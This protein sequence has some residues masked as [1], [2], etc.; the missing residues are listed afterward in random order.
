[1]T[2]KDYIST[3]VL[4]IALIY[5]DQFIINFMLNVCVFFY[6]ISNMN[7]YLEKFLFVFSITMIII[8]IIK[9]IY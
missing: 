1:M 7:S 5:L 9:I 4:S 6:I 2:T 8:S 3:I